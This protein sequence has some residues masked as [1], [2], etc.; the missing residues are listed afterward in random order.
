MRAIITYYATCSS[1]YSCLCNISLLICRGFDYYPYTLFCLVFFFFVLFC[2]SFFFFTSYSFSSLFQ[3]FSSSLLPPF[4]LTR[5]TFHYGKFHITCY[6]SFLGNKLSLSL[7][8]HRGPLFF[9]LSTSLFSKNCLGVREMRSVASK[10][11]RRKYFG[12]SFHI[13]NSIH[14]PEFQFQ[15]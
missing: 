15:F 3:H 7:S 4:L 11:K 1:C 9:L 14:L 12:S 13:L 10:K 5:Y 6:T 2:F 8:S